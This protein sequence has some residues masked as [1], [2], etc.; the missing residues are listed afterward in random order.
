LFGKNAPDGKF[1]VTEIRALPNRI[2]GEGRGTHFE[3]DPLFLYQVE[4]EIE[5]NGLEIVGFYHSHPDYEAIPSREDVENMVPGLVYMI[6]SVTRE[7][8][9]D[10]RSYRRYK[11]I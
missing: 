9:A 11:K 4:W 2:Q 7:G 3:A 6:I 8:V 1:E 10:I 5:G